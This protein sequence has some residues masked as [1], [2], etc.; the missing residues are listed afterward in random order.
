ML[1]PG[2]NPQ[3]TDDLLVHWMKWTCH[4]LG[5]GVGKGIYKVDMLKSSSW[6]GEFGVQSVSI[7]GWR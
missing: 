6:D 4:V 7:L 2:R 3:N 1:M 5:L